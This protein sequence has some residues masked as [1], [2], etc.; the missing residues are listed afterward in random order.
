MLR[1]VEGKF[2]SVTK[3][4]GKAGCT[5]GDLCAFTAVFDDRRLDKLYQSVVSAIDAVGN[6]QQRGGY[7]YARHTQPP[8]VYLRE[9]CLAHVCIGRRSGKTE[10]LRALMKEALDRGEQFVVFDIKRDTLRTSKFPVKMKF[11]FT[12]RMKRKITNS[13]PF[14][15]KIFIDNFSCMKKGSLERICNDMAPFVRDLSKIKI[16]AV[17]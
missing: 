8:E 4:V 2:D 9:C 11:Q 17:G 7:S 6:L 15:D 1:K 5:E 3:P 10:T 16:V 13:A 14:I 12:P